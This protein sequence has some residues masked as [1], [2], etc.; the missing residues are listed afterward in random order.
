VPYKGAAIHNDFVSALFANSHSCSP[1]AGQVSCSN[2][3]TP[4]S[5]LTIAFANLR[6]CVSLM[7]GILAVSQSAIPFAF[8]SRTAIHR[9]P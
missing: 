4:D 6:W 9:Y 5:L 7:P 2:V 8:L 3:A 1:H